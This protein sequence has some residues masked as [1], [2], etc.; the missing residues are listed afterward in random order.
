VTRIW[1]VLD[2]GLDQDS[3]YYEVLCGFPRSVHLSSHILPINWHDCLLPNT[4]T[5]IK[6]DYP[7][8]PFDTK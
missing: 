4:S 3:D 1:D 5:F 7:H 2:S 6:F 8:E